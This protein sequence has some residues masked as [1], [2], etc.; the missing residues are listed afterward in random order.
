[1]SNDSDIFEG[2]DVAE[3]VTPDTATPEPAAEPEKPAEPVAAKPNTVSDK[4]NSATEAAKPDTGKP[5]APDKPAQPDPR[6]YVPVG[7]HVEL[8][9]ELKQLRDQLAALQNPPKEKPAAPDFTADPKGYVD[10]RVNSALEQLE[11]ATK[12][13]KETAERADA[14]AEAT[15]FMQSLNQAEASF[16]AQ[17]PDYYDALKHIRGLREAE[18]TTLHPD[19]PLQQIRQFMAQEELQLAA[20]LMRSGRNP[21]EVAYTLAKTRGYT[22][23]AAKPAVDPAEVAKLVPAV[24]GQKQLPPDQ[25]L[26]SGSG[27]PSAGDDLPSPD[28]DMFDAAFKEMFRKRA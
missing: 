11:T 4:P 17:A 12:P 20:N 25:T 9:N 2:L 18:L 14:N 7:V 27:S 26:G 5:A 3:E 24:P 13:V 23:K 1:M 28:D 22:P 6:H 15:R 8:K 21:S 16:I 10:H 19:V